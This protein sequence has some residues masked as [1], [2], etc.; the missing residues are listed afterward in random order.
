MYMS[1][2]RYYNI[3]RVPFYSLLNVEG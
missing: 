2:K 3:I 1:G